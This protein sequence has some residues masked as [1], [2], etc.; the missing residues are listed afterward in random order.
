MIVYCGTQNAD[1]GFSRDATH[2]T[3]STRSRCQTIYDLRAAPRRA[4]RCV[5]TRLSPSLRRG[6]SLI[7]VLISMFVLLFGLMGVAAIFP[8]GNYYVVEGEKY[9]QGSALIQNALEEIEARGLLRPEA[10]LYGNSVS[11]TPFWVIQQAGLYADTIEG[12]GTRVR[13]RPI[14]VS[15][16]S[17]GPLPLCS[18]DQQSVGIYRSVAW[19]TLASTPCYLA[20]A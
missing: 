3:V 17:V 14:W 11:E 20:C 8:V 10:W 1:C 9:D 2:R 16:E 7:E 12:P 19:T 6:I 4:V 18:G 15:R 13:H 5:A